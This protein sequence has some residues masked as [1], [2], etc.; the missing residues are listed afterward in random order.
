M[1]EIY[2]KLHTKVTNESP[3]GGGQGGPVHWLTAVMQTLIVICINLHSSGVWKKR[4]Q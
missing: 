2:G 4:L 1:L 3:Q